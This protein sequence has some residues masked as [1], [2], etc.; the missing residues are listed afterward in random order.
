M[1]YRHIENLYRPQAQDILLEAEVYAMEKIHGTSAHIKWKNGQLTFFS[2][3]EKHANFIKLF[4][5]AQ[6]KAAFTTLSKV[7]GKPE[8]TVYGEAY[9]GSCQGMRSTYGDH[10]K[11]VAFEVQIGEEWQNVPFAEATVALLGLEFVHYKRIP[12]NLAAIDAE[13]DA[14]SEQAFRNGT[15]NR[16]DTSTYKVREGVVLRPLVEKRNVHDD[17][18]MAK[19]K[20]AAFQETATKREV[21]PSQ[22]Q[23]LSDAQAV[24]IEYVTEMRLNHVLDKLGNPNDIAK[25]GDVVKAMIEDVTREASGEIVDNKVVRSAIGT[26]AAKLFKLRVTKITEPNGNKSTELQEA[27]S[28]S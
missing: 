15:A 22:R 10:L 19:H 26:R 6:L 12:C 4:D 23:V 1:G 9:G 11:F 21:D 2:G 8:V 17:R 16:D 25:T 28:V 14:P 18:I 13:R 20:N 24:A 7:I 3:G 27:N 5:E